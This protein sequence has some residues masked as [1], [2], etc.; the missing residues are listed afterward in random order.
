MTGVQTC[1]L[2]ISFSATVLPSVSEGLGLRTIE[3]E[4]NVNVTDALGTRAGQEQVENAPPAPRYETKR[5]HRLKASPAAGETF[6]FQLTITNRGNSEGTDVAVTDRLPIEQLDASS[7]KFEEPEQ[8]KATFNVDTGELAWEIGV[9][10]FKNPKAKSWVQTLLSIGAI[11]GC[12]FGPLLAN[13]LGRR[14]A[15]FLLCL[16]SL[17]SCGYLFGFLTEYNMLFLAV[18][19]VAGLLSAS[20]YGWL[21]LYLPELFP[22]RVRATGQGIAFNFARIF[23]AGGTWLTGYLIDYYGGYAQACFTIILV[24]IVGMVLIWFAPETKGKPLPE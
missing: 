12:F 13:W 21:P 15:Y 6:K 17:V 19:A 3:S 4:E 14:P 8:G 7:I 20:F 11:V 18:T 22:T 1:A 9:L 24:Y 10:E 2:P 23:A 16:G 5:T